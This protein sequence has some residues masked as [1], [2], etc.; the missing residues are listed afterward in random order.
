MPMGTNPDRPRPSAARGARAADADVL[1]A[2]KVNVPRLR[3]DLLARP[4]LLDVL[5]RAAD[6][7]LVLVSTPAG[8]GKTTLLAQWAHAEAEARPVAWLSLDPDDNDPARFWRYVVAAI[9]TVHAGIGERVLPLLS[10]PEQPTPEA[11][12]GVLVSELAARPGEVWLALDDYHV[13]AARSVH[14]SLALFLERLPPRAHAVI[15]SRSDPPL[16]LSRLRARGQLAELRAADLRFTR[17]ETD[18][19]LR[20]IWGLDLPDDSVG[21]LVTRTEGWVSGLHLAALSLRGAAD[22][23]RLVRE[24][25]GSHRFVLDYLTDEV[26]E[27]QPDNVRR[28]LLDT[29]VLDRFS[30]ALCDAV[31]GRADGQ[32]MLES[33]ERANVFLVPLDAQRRWYRYHHLFADLLRARLLADDPERARALHR[34]AAAWTEDHGL[35]EDA[36]HHAMAAADPASAAR[37]VERHADALLRRGEGLTLR[38]WLSALPREAVASRPRLSL[39]LATAEVNAGRLGAAERLLGEAERALAVVPSAPPEPAVG[40]A[41]GREGSAL[42][43]V[44]A[45]IALLRA[46]LAGLRG[47]AAR[48]RDLAR[49]AEARLTKDERGPRL[50]CRWMLAVADWTSGRLAEAERAF[51]EIVAEAWRAD[52]PHLALS[53]GSLLGQVQR[54]QGRLGAALETY[55]AGLEF[56]DEA[57]HPVV[58][59]RAFAHVGIA[60]VHYERDELEAALEHATEGIALARQLTSTRVLS[61]GLTTLAWIRHAHRDGDGARVAIDEAERVFPGREIVALHRPVMAERARLLLAQGDLA[62]AALWVEERGLAESDAPSYAREPEYLMLAR[63]LLARRLPDRALDLLARLRAAAEADGRT[64]SVI[65]VGALQAI[66]LDQAGEPV[67]AV[68]VLRE[69]LTL[70]QPQGYVRIFADEGPPIAALL[71]RV[72]AAD[73]R[74]RGP[75]AEGVIPLDYLSRLRA[76]F[77]ADPT[78]RAL[79]PAPPGPVEPLTEREREV[80]ALL[81][82]GQGN[83]AIAAELVVTLDTVKKHVTHVLAKLGATSRTHA[84]ARARELALIE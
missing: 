42:A 47:N 80:L 3:E 17:E 29:A 58:L 74:R 39:V 18:A 35:V 71:G 57:D 22:P 64:G 83:R 1:L 46:S 9:D 36:L 66:A 12:V 26:L 79:R 28:F 14:D 41:A 61:E 56:A 40:G 53:A 31:T 13:I 44:P 54:A 51:A 72:G 45:A 76:P 23:T 2:T 49:A 10:A 43:N 60:Q 11:V 6:A 16:A 15:G 68:A 8:F 25:T 69:M 52:A 67:R 5:N 59:S 34:R 21:A 78:S 30:G 55:R 82:R 77:M 62:A 32:Q 84:V 38:R 7:A 50:S 65:D 75:D 70:S 81:A 4:H 19:L 48:A 24:F 37:L 33:L 73:R 63:V 20:G 27:R